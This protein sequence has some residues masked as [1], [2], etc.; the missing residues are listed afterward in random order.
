VAAWGLKRRPCVGSAAHEVIDSICGSVTKFEHYPHHEVRQ[1]TDED[2]L[3]RHRETGTAWDWAAQIYERDEQHDIHLLQTGSHTLHAREHHLLSDLSDWCRCAVHLQCA[4]GSDTLSLWR[5]GAAKVIGV[6]ISARMIA[7]AERKSAALAAPARWFCCDVLLTPDTLNGTADLVYTGRGALPWIV[8]LA[9]WARVVMR[10]L[11]P[12][13]RLLIF[14][15][16]PLDWV[17]D[18]SAPDFRFDPHD[19]HYFSDREASHRWPAPLLAATQSAV[20]GTLPNL[21][22]RQWTLGQ[23]VTTLAATGLRLVRLDEYPE[24]YWDPFKNVPPHTLHRLP[25]TFALLMVKDL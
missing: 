12:G 24:C 4:G 13:G 17:W 10:L 5:V 11:R 3:Q 16:H 7:V 20:D 22:E 21:H 1:M 18:K 19:G 6:D 8:D 23:L 15:G 2:V 9:G 14:E 25:H